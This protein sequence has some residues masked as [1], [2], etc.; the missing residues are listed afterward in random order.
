MLINRPFEFRK[1]V[2]VFAHHDSTIVMKLYYSQGACSLAPHIILEEL[3]ISYT[4]QQIQFDKGDADT[5]EFRKMSPF[6]YVP[7]LEM[8]NGT[9]LTEGVAIQLYLADQNPAM[10]LAPR[11]GTFERAKLYEWMTLLST[12]IHKGFNPL[13][14][15]QAFSK[16]PAGAEEVK[17]AVMETLGRK[18]DMVDTLIANKTYVMG[19]QFT[20]AD[21]YLFTLFNWTNYVGMKREKWPNLLAH[22]KTMMTRPAVRRVMES[23]DLLD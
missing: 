3:G 16:T 20:I 12:E 8:T 10:N 23:E 22:S 4:A 14:G 18:L 21:A 1:A 9:F 11:S 17:T 5:A 15:P 19:D 7:V 6:G 2:N 13:F